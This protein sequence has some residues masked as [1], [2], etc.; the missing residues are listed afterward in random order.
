MRTSSSTN[1]NRLSKTFSVTI[2]VPSLTA[3]SATAIGMKSVAKPGYGSVA[4][5]TAV[6]RS[7]AW[8]PDPVGGGRDAHAHLA[9]LHHDHLEVLEPHTLE[10]DLAARDPARHQDTCPPRC[11][12]P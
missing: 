6:S 7:V 3:S 11:G 9:E 2:A 12:R 1:E 4:M 5:S 8:R 10:L